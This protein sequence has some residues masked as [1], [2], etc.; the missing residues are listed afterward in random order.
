MAHSAG[1]NDATTI[2]RAIYNFRQIKPLHK[3]KTDAEKSFRVYFSL[4]ANLLA[5]AEET[6]YG[7]LPW[8]AVVL[9]Y[10]GDEQ[11]DKPALVRL[12]TIDEE[13]R[14]LSVPL[15]KYRWLGKLPVGTPLQ[16]KC[17]LVAGRLKVILL[18]ATSWYALGRGSRADSRGYECIA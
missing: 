11:P 12:V 9:Q 15:K 13:A 2:H 1:Q 17:E 7:D 3:G 14:S 5:T 8:Q 4:A 16:V 18:K 6:A 10:I